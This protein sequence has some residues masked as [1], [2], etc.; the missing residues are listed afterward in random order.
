MKTGYLYR[1]IRLD[2]NE[3]FY[4]GIGGFDKTDFEYKRAYD[5]TRRNNIWKR[6]INKT[7]YR[8]EILMDELSFIECCERK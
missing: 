7:D 5:K 4:I 6:I 8:V 1:H 2:K 3:P